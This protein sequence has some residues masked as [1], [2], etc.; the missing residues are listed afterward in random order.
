MTSKFKKF[1]RDECQEEVKEP[2]D[3]SKFCPTCVPDK[4]Y[5]EPRWWT[6][7]KPYLNAKKCEY[8]T[9]VSINKDGEM[10]THSSIKESGKSFSDVLDSYKKVGIQ[11]LL[12]F[13]N[14][15]PTN[16]INGRPIEDY[17][18]AADYHFYSFADSTMVVLVTI[19]ANVFD[20]IPEQPVIETEE[21]LMTETM[22]VKTKYL[23]LVLKKLK[24]TLSVFSKFQAMYYQLEGGMVAYEQTGEPF[25]LEF[26]PNRIDM[27]LDELE[28]IIE[29]NNY[30]YGIISD[31]L[32]EAYEL[33]F[34]FEV[35][36]ALG[37][38]KIKKI[39]ARKNFGR[40]FKTL[41]KGLSAFTKAPP[42]KDATLVGYIANV[43]NIGLRIDAKKT[44]AWTDFVETFTF[45]K[46]IATTKDN[47][48]KK[49]GIKC[50][51]DQISKVIG[52]LDDFLF[53]QVVKFSD[54][55][56]Y[57]LNKA[58]KTGIATINL[59]PDSI[60]DSKTQRKIENEF[61]LSIP[62]ISLNVEKEKKTY[63][64]KKPFCLADM[65]KNNKQ[66]SEEFL[67]SVIS[68]LN[69]CKFIE[70]S[71]TAITCIMSNLDFET[72]NRAIMKTWF[73]NATA[74]GLEGLLMGLP[75]PVRLQISQEIALELGEEANLVPTE[76][77]D[78]RE[79]QVSIAKFLI[80]S[81]TT[82]TDAYGDAL[83]ASA[84]TGISSRSNLSESQIMK[85]YEKVIMKVASI[86]DLMKS[87][88]NLP[89]MDLLMSMTGI[90]GSDFPVTHY[91]TPPIDSFL[92]S[93][94]FD[95]CGKWP[96]GLRMPKIDFKFTSWS[97][98]K[99]LG[100]M[101]IKFLRLK[102]K[103]L[104]IN[105]IGFVA[106][107]IKIEL[108]TIHSLD[109]NNVK[110]FAKAA[111]DLLTDRKDLKDIL[112]EVV[113]GEIDQDRDK[114][115][116]C[117]NLLG[118]TGL[119]TDNAMATL[120]STNYDS[121][122]NPIA[123]M[124]SP[125]NQLSDKE[126]VARAQQPF[127]KLTKAISVS[128]TKNE[129]IRAI[130]L[131]PEEQ[132]YNF[133][134]NLSLTIPIVVPEFASSFDTVEKVA[135][136][137]IKLSNTLTFD[138]RQALRDSV[139]PTEEDQPLE[140]S[141]CLTSEQVEQWNAERQ[142]AFEESGLNPDVAKD[143]V[144]KQNERIA[145]D[146]EEMLDLISRSP[147]DLFK[148]AIDRA[149]D[150][151]GDGCEN[152][153]AAFVM[154]ETPA[155][156]TVSSSVPAVFGRLQK[157]FI[158]DTIEWNFFE[159]LVDTPGILSLILADKKGFTLNYHNAVNKSAI[160]KFFLPDPG[161]NPETV[162][163][164]MLKYLE[165]NDVEFDDNKII[166]NYSNE[167]DDDD[168]FESKIICRNAKK[169][170]NYGVSCRS[171]FG[172][173]NFFVNQ[174]TFSEFDKQFIAPKGSE[175]F[176]T[177]TMQ[178]V[179]N[180]RWQK[181][182]NEINF[183][184]VN[185]ML[186]SIDRLIFTGLKSSIMYTQDG[187]VSS[188][189]VHSAPLQ[190]ITK[191]DLEYVGPN[192]EEYDYDEEQAILGRSSTNN[193]R[194][195]FLD[196]SMYGGSY[197]NPKYYIKPQEQEGWMKISRFFLPE[198]KGEKNQ[199]TFLNVSDIGKS[200]DDTR[201]KIKSDPRL[202]IAPDQLEEVPFDRVISPS[203]HAAIEG[204][205]TATIRT[206][207]ADFFIRSMPVISNV[208]I[209]PDNYD[210]CMAEFIVEEMCK[211]MQSQEH[212]L[213]S[214]YTGTVYWL[215]F[216]EQAVQIFNRKFED[217]SKIY[218][219]K[220]ENMSE[221]EKA[222]GR[223]LRKYSSSLLQIAAAQKL[224]NYDD[225]TALELLKD[226]FVWN[227]SRN[228]DN[229]S[230]RKKI[231]QLEFRIR[232]LDRIK[233]FTDKIDEGTETV[234]DSY[235]SAVEKAEKF[236]TISSDKAKSMNK[237]SINKSD[238][239]KKELRIEIEKAKTQIETNKIKKIYGD[240]IV[241]GSLIIGFGKDYWK[242]MNINYQEWNRSMKKIP[243]Y[244]TDSDSYG[245][246]GDVNLG[247]KFSDLT[248][249]EANFASK[250]FTISLV[251]KE[252]KDV[253]K[254]L[255]KEQIKNYSKALTDVVSPSITD[256]GKFFLGSSKSNIISPEIGTT[257][258]KY[259]NIVSCSDNPATSNPLDNITLSEEQIQQIKDNGNFYFEK[260]IKITEK[261]KGS[262][263]I[264]SPK[265]FKNILRSKKNV[266][267]KY[268]S[269]FFGNSI[270]NEKE[271]KMIG[272]VGVKFGLR[273]CYIPGET[274][275]KVEKTTDNL[276]IA[277]NLKSFI[278][279]PSHAGLGENIF[280]MC[281][282][283]QDLM[284]ELISFYINLPDDNCNQD[285]KCYV[286]NLM[287]SPDYD[288]IFNKIFNIKRIPS[289]LSVYSYMNF[290][291]ALGVDKNEREDS[292]DSEINKNNVGKI[293]NDC[294][295]ELKTLFLSS[296]IRKGYGLDDKNPDS[297]IEYSKDRVMKETIDANT[298]ADNIPW[299][300]KLRES[301]TN[302]FIDALGVVARNK[303]YKLFTF[304]I[305]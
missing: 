88:E 172:T 140:S 270:I 276:E 247:F 100:I 21:D 249:K 130:T 225:G 233:D 196:P 32:N 127:I 108:P 72:S 3:M 114:Q 53:N 305:E 15:V 302:P 250:I 59:G 22:T 42:M 107:K 273:L 103:D 69:P 161:E 149:L 67:K 230:L 1:Q 34:T 289:V 281:S 180:N 279:K 79:G 166:L 68:S 178:N 201:N 11:F 48:I 75:E 163:I 179:L 200:M 94:S 214:V 136:F 97:W 296:Y 60:V 235:I 117:N 282:Y 231:S 66:I 18:T 5:K 227:L 144:D 269:D 145:T 129:M 17:A 208:A 137:F 139:D 246:V 20:S 293:F 202:Q 174:H 7:E 253:L 259:N 291:S 57:Q 272:S 49:T 78:D 156:E 256:I 10:F 61:R 35:S 277:K 128:S 152:P 266:A 170:L 189:F 241:R 258:E 165:S 195:V 294:K 197:R 286:D 131:P 216:L 110:D 9:M 184:Q 40:K 141:I 58:N 8:Y 95:I 220:K 252:C 33:K 219:E 264:I 183:S 154:R 90:G 288:L 106:G 134:K 190:E 115:E 13:Y 217:F 98:P 278:F 240:D 210:D 29:L 211:S 62:E 159:R 132:D 109:C 119:T 112:S 280:P 74:Q 126:T 243:N 205:V 70:L 237:K 171:P 168:L 236:V 193:K 284:D 199:F 120:A 124:D 81:G 122:N 158:D 45:P 155:E 228:L 182:N 192:G 113:C 89:G 223:E 14:K 268:L 271:Q 24:A 207:L 198:A 73:S 52:G 297:Q 188:G 244:S 153:Q 123:T 37:T 116:L 27:F 290:L 38:Y 303:F 300:Y 135:E 263:R 86:Q 232:E 275:S 167:L 218:S 224:F 238:K 185:K 23:I 54:A 39:Q 28:K 50:V 299:F 267:G 146:L 222:L 87:I 215:L 212:A 242:N 150:I 138:Q 92:N 295:K 105:L 51:D 82:I 85:V 226:D 47:F 83:T 254:F 301:M 164:Q 91:I 257:V 173:R 255:V 221:E 265:A 2:V 160:L 71:K 245:F 41:K 31:P 46:V 194:V 19:P 274:F 142:R 204:T 16:E 292:D 213:K 203:K 118:Q 285:L 36:Q 44:P 6:T 30:S 176:R 186:K 111:S 239:I 12:N 175:D 177:I 56:E 43:K 248:L 234:L 77:P 125:S 209:G 191:Q 229:E 157:A 101:F 187:K 251:E 206:F 262:T 260:Y 4:N 283:E 25:Y 65:L 102:I 80:D 133:F 169:G 287:R 147:E 181:F 298:L 55:L 84:I 261:G 26:Y 121:L 148:D 63:R 99:A 64:I 143:F 96:S 93:L 151:E 104:I 76:E 162:S 304:L